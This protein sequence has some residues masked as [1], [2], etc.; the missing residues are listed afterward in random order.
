WLGG[1]VSPGIN[2]GYIFADADVAP[3]PGDEHGLSNNAINAVIFNL[4]CRIAPDYA[5]EAPAK[6]ITTARYGK[7]R[8]VKLSAMDRAKAA[9]CKSGYPNRMPVGSGN[10]LAKWNGWNYFHRKEPC[11]N[12]G[13]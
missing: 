12:G 9:K 8:L 6:L 7:E 3:E 4:A 5:L 2:V 13:E 11:D 1:D 10:Q